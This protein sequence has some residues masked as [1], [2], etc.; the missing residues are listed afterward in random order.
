MAFYLAFSSQRFFLL[1]LLLSGF[2]LYA[3]CVNLSLLNGR[4]LALGLFLCALL[5]FS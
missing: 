1:H 2:H 5:R 4:F 3:V